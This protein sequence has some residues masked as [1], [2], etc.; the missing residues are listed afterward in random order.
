MRA[1]EQ[2]CGAARYGGAAALILLAVASGCQ[3]KGRSGAGAKASADTWRITPVRLRVYPT[4]RFD[5][6][7]SERVLIARLEL[8]DE[9]DDPLKCV[10]SFHLELHAGV[11]VHRRRLAAWHVPVLSM[12]QQRRY[13]DS[14]SRT[15][16]LPLQIVESPPPKRKLL[17]RARF[18]PVDA[19][20]VTTEAEVGSD[21]RAPV[22]PMKP[23]LPDP[24]SIA[25]VQPGA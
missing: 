23:P 19:P 13:Y 21:R 16:R 17:L 1:R 15:Y 14:I 8:L 10:G 11:D 4:T 22:R 3:F 18:T 24:G 9:M 25:P 5:D 7:E 2:T 6:A 20:R 12:Q